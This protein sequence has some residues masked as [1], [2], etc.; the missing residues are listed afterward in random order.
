M[1]RLHAANTHSIMER[2]LWIGV[3]GLLLCS[4]IV[5]GVPYSKYGRSCKDIGCRS[6]EICVMAEDPCTYESRDRCGRYPTCTRNG[7]AGGLSCTTLV[8]PSGQ[9]C[10]S[11]DGH[12][13]C[14]NT[15]SNIGYESAGVSS[16]NGQPT[17]ADQSHGSSSSNYNPYSNANA[18]P[19]P[20]HDSN[21]HT[22]NSANNN[23]YPQYPS[24][25]GNSGYAGYPRPPS[26]GSNLGYPPYPTQNRMPQPGVY[27]SGQYPAGN[28]PGYHNNQ[29]PG[30]QYPNYPFNQNPYMTH[31][32]RYNGAASQSP[33]ILSL[34]FV[35][36]LLVTVNTYLS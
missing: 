17:N 24:T 11:I 33:E 15:N 31:S 27:Q 26:S 3:W 16:I 23:G 19:D 7:A 35:S 12:A 6:N 34:C 21:Y 4:S 22:V 32:R 13:T 29:Q 10:K 18:P 1:D 2:T 36:L 28:Y 5:N 14:V 9:Y 25:S 30:H 8:C 20:S